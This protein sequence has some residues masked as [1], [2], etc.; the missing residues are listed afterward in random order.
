MTYYDDL[1]PYTYMDKK[2]G[3]ALIN[4]GWLDKDHIYNKGN[5]DE[6]ILSKILMLCMNTQNRT[7]GYHVCPYCVEPLFGIPV[8]INGKTIKLGSAEIWVP[9]DDKKVF[10][11]PDLIYHYIKEHNYLPPKEFI[12]AVRKL[13]VNC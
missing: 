7:R 4:V 13:N 5:V 2:D 8:V 10:I 11:A 12:S 3:R 1:T 9:D 6:G